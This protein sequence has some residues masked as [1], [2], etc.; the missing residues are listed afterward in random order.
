MHEYACTY[1]WASTSTPTCTGTGIGAC[2]CISIYIYICRYFTYTHTYTCTC[3]LRCTYT[4]TYP[5]TFT[6]IIYILHFEGKHVI[7]S[8]LKRFRLPLHAMEIVWVRTPGATV[9]IARFF[10]FGRFYIGH[11]FWGYEKLS[12]RQKLVLRAG[13]P[14]VK[15]HFSYPGL[16]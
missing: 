4:S 2:T 1:M 3:T 9:K 15:H 13:F 8:L 6:L 5:V 7:Y 14:H 12:L 10:D 16:H 11:P